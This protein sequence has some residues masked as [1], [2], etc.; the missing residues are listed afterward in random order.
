PKRVLSLATAAL[1]LQICLIFWFSALAKYDPAWRRDG[2]AVFMALSIGANATA[3]AQM[4]LPFHELLR[5]L[6]FATLIQEGV[7]P[8]LLFVPWKTWVFRLLVVASFVLFHIGLALCMDLG[9]FE[10]VCITGWLVL[11]PTEFWDWLAARRM[12]RAVREWWATL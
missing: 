2:Y 7:V 12:V 11:L 1:L 8:F 5:V 9:N 4:L 10:Y 3:F 6:T